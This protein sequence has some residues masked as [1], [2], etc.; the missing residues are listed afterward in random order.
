MKKA[1]QLLSALMLILFLFGTAAAQ[2][3]L[4][5]GNSEPSLL[6][7]L[8]ERDEDLVVVQQNGKVTWLSGDL[9]DTVVTDADSAWKAFEEL[10]P[11]LGADENTE[12]KPDIILEDD[13]GFTYYTYMQFYNSISVIDSVVKLIVDPLGHVAGIVG[14]VT[15]IEPEDY[16]FENTIDEKRGKPTN[17]GMIARATEVLRAKEAILWKRT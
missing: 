1:V 13:S 10:V 15:P 8:K 5:G 3:D 2:L 14:K 17:G 4:T 12:Y 9:T 6:D 16:D 11:V 7:K